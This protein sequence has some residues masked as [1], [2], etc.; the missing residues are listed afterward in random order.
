MTGF[1]LELRK[2]RMRWWGILTAACSIAIALLNWERWFDSLAAAS[3][4]SVVPVLYVGAIP[5]AGAA[6][7]EHVRRS[8]SLHTLGKMSARANWQVIA[9]RLTALVL[10]GALIPVTVPAAVILV[11]ASFGARHGTA[12]WNPCT[13][14]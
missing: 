9:A 2:S 5:V 6:D 13:W 8:T 12:P 14:R 10:Y 7:E 4:W 3:I 1:L 11:V